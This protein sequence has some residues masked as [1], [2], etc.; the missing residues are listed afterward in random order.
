MNIFRATKHRKLWNLEKAR[1]IKY[2]S[3]LSSTNFFVT[4]LM[5]ALYVLQNKYYTGDRIKYFF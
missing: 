3:I 4:D 1:Q 5:Y 2:E